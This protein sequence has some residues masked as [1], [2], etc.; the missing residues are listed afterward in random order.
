MSSIILCTTFLWINYFHMATQDLIFGSLTTLG[1]YSSI[2]SC[3][4]K[5]IFIC[6]AGI[7]IGLP[8]C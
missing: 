6:F 4:T 7:W 1:I 2:K 8:L 3:K 5:I